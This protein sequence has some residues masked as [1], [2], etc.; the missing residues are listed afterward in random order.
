MS[1]KRGSLF[2][3]VEAMEEPVPDSPVAPPVEVKPKT[4]KAATRI[5]K[6]VATTYLEPEAWKQL[7][8]IAIDENA[9]VEALLR[10]GLNHVF[11]ARSMTRMA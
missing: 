5:G 9:T 1:A 7:Q 6:R 2:S 4:Q 3:V 10:E 11:A 8:L